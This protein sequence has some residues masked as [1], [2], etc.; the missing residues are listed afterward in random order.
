MQHNI[1]EGFILRLGS[2]APPRGTQPCRGPSF[3][4]YQDGLQFGV[5]GEEPFV[6]RV[7]E[8]VL[9]QVSPEPPESLGHGDL[10]T[11]LGPDDGG[12]LLGHVQFLV[13]PRLHW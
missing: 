12:E 1:P 4:L 9:P 2:S 11:S 10:L 7:L 3:S 6:L 5:G 13:D 8:V